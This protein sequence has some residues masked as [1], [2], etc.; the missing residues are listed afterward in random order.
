MRSSSFLVLAIDL[1]M[2]LVTD[3]LLLLYLQLVNF[4]CMHPSINNPKYNKILKSKTIII[5][6]PIHLI[7]YQL[8]TQ[9]ILIFQTLMFL[10]QFL[11][12]F[13]VRYISIFNLLT[14]GVPLDSITWFYFCSEVA[15]TTWFLFWLADHF[16]G[17]H[18]DGF[19]TA[20]FL[21]QGDCFVWVDDILGCA[22]YSIFTMPV[23]NFGLL[24][25]PITIILLHLGI[26]YSIKLINL[27][28]F[29]KSFKYFLLTMFIIKCRIF[30]NSKCLLGRNTMFT[31]GW[32]P[33][34]WWE[35]WW[36]VDRVIIVWF[37]FTGD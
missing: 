36:F 13:L 9:P 4:I 15:I 21:G 3:I 25:L 12:C 14:L 6:D 30:C 20:V 22:V 35:I 33:A 28:K 17:W 27:L 32:I 2:W 11:P 34:Y 23:F 16:G 26:R 19:V 18:Y 29:I 10:Y 1:F 8:P 24:I 37:L 5:I 7:L 31:V